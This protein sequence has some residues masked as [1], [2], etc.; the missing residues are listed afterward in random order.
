MYL[1]RLSL[2]VVLMAMKEFF[3]LVRGAMEKPWSVESFMPVRS[4]TFARAVKTFS[5]EG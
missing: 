5:R 2:W 3:L 1:A 4:S